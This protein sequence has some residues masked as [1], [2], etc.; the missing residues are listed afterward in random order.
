MKLKHVAGVGLA[1]LFTGLGIVS[2]IETGWFSVGTLF[3]GFAGGIIYTVW[4][5]K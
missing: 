4:L 1:L 5:H 3:F 2:V